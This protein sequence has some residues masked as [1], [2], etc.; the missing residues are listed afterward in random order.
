MAIT[1]PTPPTPPSPPKI[2]LGDAARDAQANTTH[3]TGDAQAEQQARES[4][5]QGNGA[6][7]KTT[8]GAP[9]TGGTAER[10]NAAARTDAAKGDAVSTSAAKVNRGTAVEGQTGADVAKGLDLAQENAALKQQLANTEQKPPEAPTSYTATSG[11]YWAGMIAVAL[12]LGVVFFR[13]FFQKKPEAA[14]TEEPSLGE[15]ILAHDRERTARA[16]ESH[17]QDTERGVHDD[18]LAAAEQTR[19]ARDTRSELLPEFT[20]LTAGEALARLAEEEQAAPHTSSPVDTPPRPIP[21]RSAVAPPRTA[22]TKV[23][24]VI[25]SPITSSVQK[26]SVKKSTEKRDDAEEKPRFEVRV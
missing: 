10:P 22:A 5:A 2:T 20:G 25:P 24:P 21:T 19:R 26:T 4:V 6:L 8:T 15:R 1:P 13:R 17:A 7:S 14:A 12:V 9:K 16:H 11:L 3:T 23:P 18:L